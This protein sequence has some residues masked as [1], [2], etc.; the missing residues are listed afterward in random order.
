MIRDAT[1]ADAEVIWS[2][3]EP[4]IRAGDTYAL[5]KDLSR[6][7]ALEYWMA[8]GQKCFVAEIDGTVCGT[9]YLKPNQAGGGA[10]VANCGYIVAEEARGHGLARAMCKHS[11]ELACDLGYTAMQFNFVVSTNWRALTLWQSL[12]FKRVG[13][14]PKAFDHPS[15]G[16]VDALVLF[17]GL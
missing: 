2:I 13:R 10:H 5:D 11:Q 12:G 7:E 3:L 17:K 9:Y 4:I 6:D 14:L 15:K 1:K 8:L 16:L